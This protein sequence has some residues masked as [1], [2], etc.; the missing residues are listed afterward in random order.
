MDEADQYSDVFTVDGTSELAAADVT[1]SQ[2]QQLT[3]SEDEEERCDEM[4]DASTRDSRTICG[5]SLDNVEDEL[6]SSTN[7]DSQTNEI[8]PESDV[9]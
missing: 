1:S 9:E 3:T 5:I 6:H 2:H 7:A 8:I 4:W